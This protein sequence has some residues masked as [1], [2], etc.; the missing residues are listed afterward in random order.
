MEATFPQACYAAMAADDIR[1]NSS[2][3]GAFTVFA[4][5]FLSRGGAVCGAAFDGDFRCRHEI[6]RDEAG[7]ARLRGSKYVKAPLSRDF[8]EKLGNTLDSGIPVLFSGVP[9]QVAAVNR[10]FAGRARTLCTIDLIC[11]GAPDQPLFDRYL[12]E[13]WGRENILRYEFRNKSRGWHHHHYL[14][15]VVLKDGT[16]I[17]REKG[18]DEYMSSMSSALGL[19]P[20]CFNCPFCTMMRQGDVTMGDFWQA[21]AEMD[22]AKG[23]SAIL[24]NTEKGRRLFESV[25]P[26]FAKI[27]EYPPSSIEEKQIRLRRPPTPPRGRVLFRDLLASGKTLKD[28]LAGT[29]ADVSWNVAVLNFHW[30]TVNFGA[31][32][33]A[34]ALNRCL[35]DMG[36]NV[37]NI[38]F[39]PDL[40]RVAA[41]PPNAKFDE[42]RRKRIPATQNIANAAALKNLNARFGS[43]VAGSDQVWNPEL[44]G[45]FQDV[46]FL[47]FANPSKR[48]VSAAAS[49][50]A[51]PATAYGRGLLAKLAGAF[52]RVGVR[53]TSAQKALSALGVP[54]NTVADPV[55]LLPREEWRALASSAK[56]PCGSGD[57]VWYAVNPSGKRGLGEYFRTHR[58]ECEGRLFRLDASLGVEEWLSAVADAPLVVTDS[59][60]AVCFALLFERPFAV[61]ASKNPKS[62]RI[63]ELLEGAGLTDRL[64][65]DPAGMPSPA[66]LAKPLDGDA[67]R[68]RID[69][70]RGGLAKFL[71]EALAAPVQPDPAR[72]A[73]RLAAVRA[74]RRAVDGSLFRAWLRAW[75]GIG[76]IAVKFALAKNVSKNLE[77]LRKRSF[78]IEGMKAQRRRLKAAEAELKKWKP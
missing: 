24:V 70:M 14:L 72:T 56:R 45:W 18:E 38:D 3:G 2:S 75:L 60:H 42:F 73:K 78:A 6:V 37:R 44:T 43:F 29:L 50:G 28:A 71:E 30:E 63:K 20:G 12:D 68:A 15:H 74:M 51:D 77:G 7:L 4:R 53:E 17:W 65:D 10:R 39:K 52:D 48:L 49:F 61:L 47:L 36:W 41:K 11:A 25:R 35:R 32:L 31:V 8:L 27:A 58:G 55:F 19:S 62:R 59:F 22:D 64:F 34:Y 21:P 57:I 46:Y 40:P 16:E 26:A 76:K 13:N 67:I 33:T 1:A 69:A 9:C 23:T 66:E 54:A 5:S